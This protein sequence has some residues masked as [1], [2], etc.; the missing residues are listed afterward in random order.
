MSDSKELSNT[1]ICH[2][3]IREFGHCSN[4][5]IKSHSH[6]NTQIIDECDS[7]ERKESLKTPVVVSNI[8]EDEASRLFENNKEKIIDDTRSALKSQGVDPTA[9]GMANKFEREKRY[10]V[11]KA[12]DLK[13]LSDDELLVLCNIDSKINTMR[14][15]D[16][17]RKLECAVIEADWSIHD[18]AW[19]LIEKQYRLDQSE[20]VR[21]VMIGA[22]GERDYVERFS[23]E[24]CPCTCGNRIQYACVLDREA[25]KMAAIDLTENWLSPH[26]AIELEPVPIEEQSVAVIVYCDQGTG[27]SLHAE[28]LKVF[29]NCSE[30]IEEWMP[31]VNPIT[32][33]ALHLTHFRT[34]SFENHLKNENIKCIH[35]NDA[36]NEMAGD[37]QS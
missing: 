31:W 26:V 14:K 29:Y 6:N 35:I 11:I 27:K 4:V 16:G 32:P 22:R 24:G 33:Y 19:A 12:T 3:C 13:Y 10:T 15:A 9:S 1:S 36:L 5:I 7:F 2:L 20:K 28:N 37:H 34:S 23:D 30:I 8:P 21:I 18:E 17:K 25:A